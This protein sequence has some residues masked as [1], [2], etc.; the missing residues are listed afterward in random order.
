[1]M[2]QPP[3]QQPEKWRLGAG[4]CGPVSFATNLAIC[5]T[6]D[7]SRHS[8]LKLQKH[9]SQPRATK[10]LTASNYV[11]HVNFGHRSRELFRESQA[12]WTWLRILGAGGVCQ[13]LEKQNHCDVCLYVTNCLP[14][15]VTRE[16]YKS[17]P[18]IDSWIFHTLNFWCKVLMSWVT[19]DW[20]Y[21]RSISVL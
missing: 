17:L 2:P 3:I 11:P 21:S 19:I 20:P 13:K 1:M 5:S 6:Y 16:R 9:R 10:M 15:S 14:L 18:I 12:L 7:S 8:V 4:S